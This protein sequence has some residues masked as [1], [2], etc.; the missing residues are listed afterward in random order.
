MVSICNDWGYVY[1]WFNNI[2]FGYIFYMEIN[3]L[4]GFEFVGRD[5]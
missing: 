4:V 5:F 2:C 3:I 1:F